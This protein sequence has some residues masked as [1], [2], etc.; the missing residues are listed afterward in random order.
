MNRETSNNILPSRL[1]KFFGWLIFTLTLAVALHFVIIWQIPSFV[2]NRTVE[3]I[4]ARKKTREFNRLFHNDL[5][6][7]GT[8]LVVMS[9]AD[10]KSSFAAYDVSEKPV[11]I[12]C[13]V[14]NTDNYWSISLFAWNTDNF[15][16][17]NDRN[18]PAREFDLI[19]VKSGSKYQKKEGEEVVVSPT[20]KGIVLLRYIVSDRSNQEEINFVTAEQNKSFAQ[21]LETKNY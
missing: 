18:A 8:D 7:A 6:Y 11:K 16:V 9:N 5:S 3:G 4:F 1:P 14:P 12:H 21:V 13:V 15:Y 17:R 19:I 10:M 2:T 20:E